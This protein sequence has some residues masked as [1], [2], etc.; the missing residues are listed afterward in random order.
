MIIQ[1]T[2]NLLHLLQV[3]EDLPTMINSDYEAAISLCLIIHSNSM[4]LNSQ[5]SI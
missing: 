3:G 4:L 1:L 5:Y 2:F